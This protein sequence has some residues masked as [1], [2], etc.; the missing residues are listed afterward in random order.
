[1]VSHVNFTERLDKTIKGYPNAIGQALGPTIGRYFNT[2]LL[3]ETVGA[4]ASAKRYIRTATTG[5]IDL[6]NP[7]PFKI[8]D[9]L[10]IGTGLATIFN[11]LKDI[12]S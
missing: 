9:K 4:G 3:T 6:K 12:K 8:E 10:P 7:A 5:T 1:M 11:K 2:F